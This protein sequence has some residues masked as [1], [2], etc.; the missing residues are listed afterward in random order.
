MRYTVKPN[1]ILR[2][3]S[4]S[5][6]VGMKKVK[7]RALMKAINQKRK[8]ADDRAMRSPR[9]IKTRTLNR[10]VLKSSNLSNVLCHIRHP[11]LPAHARFHWKLPLIS[12]TLYTK[13][14]HKFKTHLNN[15]QNIAVRSSF[16]EIVLTTR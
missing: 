5:V 14:K 11:L 3:L 8:R 10:K 2:V 6:T 16:R 15:M 9:I 1:L 7:R 13:R 12:L 4:E